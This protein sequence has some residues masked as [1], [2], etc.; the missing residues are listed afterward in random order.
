MFNIGDKVV[1]PMHGAGI[2][3]AIEEKEILGK[4]RKYYI[5]KM[6]LGD[7]KVMIPLE[8]VEDIG[9]REIIS[10]KEVDQVMAVLND[11]ISK[12]PK[13][14]NRRYRANMDKI[15]SGDIYEVAMVVRNLTLRDR[16][17]GLST[18]ERKMLANA[19]QILVS[20]LVLAGSIE[21]DKAEELINE[22]IQ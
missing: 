14:W 15:K 6:P 13:N 16:E 21:E 17:K 8:N 22:A 18:G 9:L 3:E 12:M 2:I 20:E 4:K 11:D 1:Y 5:M 19:K 10:F 7:M